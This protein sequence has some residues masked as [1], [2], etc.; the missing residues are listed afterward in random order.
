M[1]ART[2]FDLI[3][4]FDDPPHSVAALVTPKYGV[5][6]VLKWAAA[7]GVLFVST[8]ILA[9]FGYCLAAEHALARAARAGAREATLPRATS[10]SIV[11]SVKRRLSG[12]ALQYSALQVSVEQNGQPVRGR[13]VARSGDE[14]SVVVSLSTAAVV[15]RWSQSALV[16]RGET[17]IH[18]R[19]ENR[20]PGRELKIA[21]RH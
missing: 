15:P 9:D 1:D 19:A 13:F 8:C 16:W 20:L 5:G 3:A 2:S 6:W 17:Q 12:Y 14:I 18:A 7:L 21:E 4:Y 10:A 11:A